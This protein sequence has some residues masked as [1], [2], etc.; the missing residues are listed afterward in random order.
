MRNSVK[1]LRVALNVFVY[2]LQ[3]VPA[4]PSPPSCSCIQS[5]GQYNIWHVHLWNSIKTYKS[6]MPLTA[7]G[8]ES[9]SG[10]GRMQLTRWTVQNRAVNRWLSLLPIGRINCGCFSVDNTLYDLWPSDWCHVLWVTTDLA[11]D[12]PLCRPNQQ[13][14]TTV[15]QVSVA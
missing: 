12:S 5:I 3:S 4:R 10:T 7:T 14:I 13:C 9:I 8:R 2:N 15:S 11:K 6:G 1:R